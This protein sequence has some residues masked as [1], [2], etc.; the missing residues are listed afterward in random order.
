VELRR[1]RRHLPALSGAGWMIGLA[2]TVATVAMVLGGVQHYE[3][4]L[5]HH[6]DF[7]RDQVEQ[8]L[9]RLAAQSS[10]SRQSEPGMVDGRQDIIVGGVL[11][12]AEVMA[13]FDRDRCLT[14]E[15]DILDGL[16][17]SLR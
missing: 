11:V 8:C 4:R 7:T 5:V 13:V 12:L 9:A 2:G 16:A 3:R 1:A 17:A 10:S 15:D 6:V 14:S